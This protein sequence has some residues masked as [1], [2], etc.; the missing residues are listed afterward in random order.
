VGGVD[1]NRNMACGLSTSNIGDHSVE[2]VLLPLLTGHVFMFG[3][4]AIV[5]RLQGRQINLSQQ[6]MI[7]DT[8]TTDFGDPFLLVSQ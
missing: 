4:P 8:E 1:V 5:A 3:L 7:A 2:F 6:V